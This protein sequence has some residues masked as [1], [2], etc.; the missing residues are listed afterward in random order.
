MKRLFFASTFFIAAIL[1]AFLY[2]YFRDEGSAVGI[3]FAKPD[4]IL[5]G[6]PFAFTVSASNYSDKIAKDVRLSLILPEGV[7]FLGRSP[8]QRVIEQAIGDLGPGSFNQQTFNLI[9]LGLKE[10]EK[11]IEAKVSYKN[12]NESS[13]RFEFVS[14]TDIYAGKPVVAVTIKAPEGIASGENFSFE[15]NYQNNSKQDFKDVAITL[16]YPPNFQFVKG[17]PAPTRSNNEWEIPHLESGSKGSINLEG[18][19]IGGE[20][21]GFTFNVSLFANFLGEKYLISSESLDLKISSEPLSLRLLVNDR[22]DYVSNI[23]EKLTYKIVFKNKSDFSIRNV[24]FNLALIG[25]LVDF[26]SYESDGVYNSVTHTFSWDYNKFPDLQVLDAGEEKNFI[27]SVSLKSLYP[28]R[29]LSD[30]NYSV[31]AKAEVSGFVIDSNNRPKK[32]ISLADLETKVSGFIKIDA[33]AYFRDAESGFLNI[34]PYPPKVGT[35]T[36]YTVHWLISNYATD[37]SSIKVSASLLGNRWTGSVKSNT[38]SAP[39]YNKETGEVIWEIESLPAT[40]GVISEPAEAV[41]QV[42]VVPRLNHLGQNVPIL[43]AT[44]IRAKDDFTGLTLFNSDFALDSFL[45]DDP[46]VQNTVRFVQP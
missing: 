22:E 23:G 34:G 8:E 39:S 3:E 13:A 1:A 31:K 30:K 9:A 11:K 43:G 29:R 35:A 14:H 18:N 44:E 2:F 6:E 7:A 21:S 20:G 42:E 27:A 24:S 25:E 36:Q 10:G 37:V 32:I 38:R 33:K 19:I 12:G 45:P 4:Q 28:I 16:S 40:K 15:V 41:F 17:S 26:S 46:T 5:I